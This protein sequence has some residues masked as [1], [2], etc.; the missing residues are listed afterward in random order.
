MAHPVRTAS[1][2]QGGAAGG[3]VTALVYSKP[4]S[5]WA[6]NLIYSLVMLA[7]VQSYLVAVLDDASLSDC[8]AWRLPCVDARWAMEQQQHADAAAGEGSL[9]R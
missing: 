9:A 1:Q 2:V 7:K 4:T 6:L 3:T 5:R 8:R